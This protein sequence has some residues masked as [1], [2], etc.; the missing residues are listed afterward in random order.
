MNEQCA[1]CGATNL[2]F[3]GAGASE[4][5][6]VWQTFDCQACSRYTKFWYEKN[7]RKDDPP[8]KSELIG[9]AEIDSDE[10]VLQQ[11]VIELSVTE[12]SALSEFLKRATFNNYRLRATNAAEAYD[13]QIAAA[14]VREAL[15]NAGFAPR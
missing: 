7:A 3:E 8:I 1:Y 10:D 5:S 11:F 15:A 6:L 13:M 14:K 2:S 12:A 4:N 9:R